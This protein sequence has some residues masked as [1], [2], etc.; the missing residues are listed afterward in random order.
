MWYSH[1][2]HVL[3]GWINTDQLS[4]YKNFIHI[5]ISAR[6]AKVFEFRANYNM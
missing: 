2:V 4:T 1:T 6:P 5:K 3:I